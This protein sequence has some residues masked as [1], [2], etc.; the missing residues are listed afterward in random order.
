MSLQKIAEEMA[1]LSGARWRTLANLQKLVGRT[2]VH[3]NLLRDYGT[4]GPSRL[5]AIRGVQKTLGIQ[6]TKTLEGTIVQQAASLPRARTTPSKKILWRSGVGSGGAYDSGL[7]GRGLAHATPTPWVNT[8]YSYRRNPFW[9]EPKLG[10]FS[11]GAAYKSHKN[12]KYF[13]DWGLETFLTGRAPV[14][15]VPPRVLADM[16][17]PVPWSV[18]EGTQ[19][20]ETA[21]HPKANPLLGYFMDLPKLDG[22]RRLLDADSLLLKAILSAIK[23][24]HARSPKYLRKEIRPDRLRDLFA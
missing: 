3:Q 18:G 6:P 10:K 5:E 23:P 16:S 13:K 1:K 14:G 17:K 19:F 20:L 15:D 7:F 9:N 4:I 22:S 2:D 12:Q 21:V 11:L 8:V 24:L